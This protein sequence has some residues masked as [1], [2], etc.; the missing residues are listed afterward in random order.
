MRQALRLALEHMS[1]G[2]GGPFGAVVVRA[3]EV[4]GEGWN[5]VIATNDPTAHAEVQA[6][7]AACARLGRFELPDCE[8]YTS[9]EPCPMCLGAAYWARIPRIYFAAD[10]HEAARGGFQDEDM[11]RELTLDPAERRVALVRCLPDEGRRPFDAWLAKADR[12]PY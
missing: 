8:L 9:C 7:R 1:A 4:V 2:E 3:G 10:R 6:I 12:V 5:R 11:Y